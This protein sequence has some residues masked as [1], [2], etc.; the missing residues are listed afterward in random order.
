YINSYYLR[1]KRHNQGTLPPKDPILKVCRFYFLRNYYLEA[2]FIYNFNL[3][4]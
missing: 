3:K 1:I 4:Y 2:Y